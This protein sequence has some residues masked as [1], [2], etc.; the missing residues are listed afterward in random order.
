MNQLALVREHKADFLA[1]YETPVFLAEAA[2]AVVSHQWGNPLNYLYLEVCWQ[3]YALV[4]NSAALAAQGVGLYYHGF[5]AREAAATLLAAW[6]APR[7]FW[8]AYRERSQSWLL[9]LDPR[10]QS[11]REAFAQRLRGSHA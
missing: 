9:T 5:R 1:R 11:V 4:H 3:G 10:A 8:D 7:E 6:R 2:D